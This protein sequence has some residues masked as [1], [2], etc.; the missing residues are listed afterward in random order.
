MMKDI[1]SRKI[2]GKQYSDLPLASEIIIDLKMQIFR[3]K[4]LTFSLSAVL[5]ITLLTACT[6]MR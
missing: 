5:V 3:Y 1:M 2:Y 6:L 4:I